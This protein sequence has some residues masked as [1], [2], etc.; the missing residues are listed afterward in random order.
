MLSV[1]VLTFCKVP[2]SRKWMPTA[3]IIC[4]TSSA[5]AD[6]QNPKNLLRLFLGLLII[7]TRSLLLL[8][9]LLLLLFVF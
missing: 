4:A 1:S 2:R 5:V 6:L 3:E 8:L 7:L 9:L